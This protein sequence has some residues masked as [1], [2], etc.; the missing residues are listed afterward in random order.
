[1]TSTVH[2]IRSLLHVLLVTLL[3]PLPAAAFRSR[4]LTDLRFQSIG[5]GRLASAATDGETFMLLASAA[6]VVPS[7]F[8]QKAGADGVA[9]GPRLRIGDGVAV[10]IGWSGTEYLA[11]WR[12]DRGLWLA[13]VSRD[14]ALSGPA[15]PV[16]SGAYRYFA[17]GT[18]SAVALGYESDTV[19]MQLLDL[20]GN[21]L[22][23]EARFAAPEPAAFASL[24]SDFGIV[25]TGSSTSF[26]R[27][28]RNGTPVSAPISIDPRASSH[29]ALASDG[30]DVMVAFE[31]TPPIWQIKN[32][33]VRANGSIRN[34]AQT[35]PTPPGVPMWPGAL[36]WDGSQYILSA[37][38]YASALLIR[39][40]RAGAAIGDAAPLGPTYGAPGLALKPNHVLVLYPG[41]VA[42]ATIA[43]F[44][45]DTAHPIGQT[46]SEQ[47][48]IKLAAK[49]GQYLAVWIEMTTSGV[50][51]RATRINAAGDYLDGEGIVLSVTPDYPSFRPDSLAVDSD[52]TH[53]L[54]LWADGEVHGTRISRDGA[55]LD[56]TPIAL[57]PGYEAA[58]RWNGS[59]Y[60][61]LTSDRKTIS[62]V[63]VG[64]NGAAA[65]PKVLVRAAQP[66]IF[67]VAPAIASVRGQTLALFDAIE[68]RFPDDILDYDVAVE[69]LRLDE[70][71]NVLEPAPL[72]LPE[73]LSGPKSIAA[74]DTHYLVA[75]SHA[76]AL[77]PIDAP[78]TIATEWPVEGDVFDAAYDGHDFYVAW[79][80][81]GSAGIKRITSSGSLTTT[82][83]RADEAEWN[84]D[85][86]VA[87][88]SNTPALFGF[89]SI[90]PAY[91]DVL[92]GN[93]LFLS[94]ITATPPV[95]AS[96]A[97]VGASRVDADT[98]DVRWRLPAG[99]LLGIA[100]EARLP[101]GGWRSI[102][103]APAGKT[104]TRVTLAG[105]RASAVRLRGWNASGTSESSAEVVIAPPK[106]RAI[107]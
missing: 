2:S 59:R 22:R 87:A 46:L 107:R 66:Q 94:E 76:L 64:A 10:G 103:V 60:L 14:G 56:A 16:A 84:G 55:K 96:P 49:N 1:M 79:R 75:T 63:A 27:L 54:V 69:G 4:P 106:Q 17:V 70:F 38:G 13:H 78:Q 82:T 77:L 98:I 45:L 26:M 80:G 32:V 39:L 21:A 31:T 83:M 53:W 29:A 8:V 52:G 19:L 81:S 40:D 23:P 25:F 85:L 65:S 43:P 30:S 92:R 100:I 71:G 42:L 86:S 102:A 47:R 99:P 7:V 12:N 35:I 90:H 104:S 6:D 72:T 9:S 44:S 5:D 58:V 15:T 24:G 73:S 68:P 51:V 67:L 41:K 105:L 33:V 62:S 50:E 20:G 97:I 61:V 88:G 95:P 93:L 11:A 74:N 57:G 89:I 18:Q 28:D 34:A 36:V 91:D 101:D 3:F 48:R 37:G